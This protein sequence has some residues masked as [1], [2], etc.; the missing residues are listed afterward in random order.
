MIANLTLYWTEQVMNLTAT[1]AQVRLWWPAGKGPH[2]L[3]NL[4]VALDQPS[5]EVSTSRSVGFRVMSLVT[6]NDTD[7]SAHAK[8]SGAGEAQLHAGGIVSQ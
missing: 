8:D 3:Y 6:T 1:A 7:A 2:P 5:G 4:T